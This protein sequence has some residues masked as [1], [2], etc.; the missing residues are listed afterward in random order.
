MKHQSIF[1]IVMKKTASVLKQKPFFIVFI[2]TDDLFLNQIL[3][4]KNRE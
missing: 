3:F 1:N 2:N 4:L